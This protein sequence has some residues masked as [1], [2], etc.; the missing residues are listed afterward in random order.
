M[1]S[2][3]QFLDEKIICFIE[4]DVEIT[5]EPMALELNERHIIGVDDSDHHGMTKY[6]V[7]FNFPKSATMAKYKNYDTEVRYILANTPQEARERTIEFVRKKKMQRTSGTLISRP[8]PYLKDISVKDM[9]IKVKA[10]KTWEDFVE[11][12]EYIM[13]RKPKN[14]MQYF[15]Q[16][17]L[18]IFLKRVKK[19][20]NFNY[21]LQDMSR[22]MQLFLKRL[23]KHTLQQDLSPDNRNLLDQPSRNAPS[24][25]RRK[26]LDAS[27]RM[28]GI[29]YP[30]FKP[31]DPT[32]PPNVSN[33]STVLDIVKEAKLYGI[34]HKDLKGMKD[35]IIAMQY[36]EVP[37]RQT[38]WRDIRERLANAN[39]KVQKAKSIFYR[40][41]GY[42]QPSNPMFHGMDH[43]ELDKFGA[44][45]WATELGRQYPWLA[46]YDRDIYAAIYEFYKQGMPKM[47]SAKDL[48]YQALVRILEQKQYEKERIWYKE[49]ET[50]YEEIPF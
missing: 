15:S 40:G 11:L 26:A 47:P 16:D 32:E 2:F 4:D 13:A 27:S 43:T 44:D 10:V 38:A 29:F 36:S 50:S 18:N 20:K 1:K 5:L 39:Y 3:V 34:S 46:H 8:A 41:K 45:E 14:A 6:R 42:I 25:T 24:I 22:E 37:E 21:E 17:D 12:A 19:S 30:T 35:E 49:P 31:K 28:M 33:Q 7:T 48:W 9:G 23:Y